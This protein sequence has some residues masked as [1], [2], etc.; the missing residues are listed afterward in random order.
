M[1]REFG[2][3]VGWSDEARAEV[4]AQWSQAKGAQPYEVTR[5]WEALAG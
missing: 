4:W 3:V 2:D 1:A 5:M